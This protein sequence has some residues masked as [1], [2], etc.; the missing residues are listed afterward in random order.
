MFLNAF[1]DINPTRERHCGVFLGCIMLPASLAASLGRM[2]KRN[3][4]IRVPQRTLLFGLLGRKTHPPRENRRE[5][6]VI[7]ARLHPLGISIGFG[8]RQL[9]HAVHDH[10]GLEERREELVHRPVE[11][12]LEQSL[13]STSKS[14][15]DNGLPTCF[16]GWAINAMPF[17]GA[18]CRYSV[19]TLL[20]TNSSSPVTGLNLT[21]MLREALEVKKTGCRTVAT[22][23]F[24]THQPHVQG[25]KRWTYTP[26]SAS[27]R[28]RALTIGS[29]VATS[30]MAMFMRMT[31][32]PPRFFSPNPRSVSRRTTFRPP[33]IS[34]SP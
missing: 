14:T 1:Q 9:L 10:P 24:G 22:K 18:T 2:L 15:K 16:S 13:N 17:A 6:R 29:S 32:K 11:V 21:S 23:L 33:P 27:S 26:S 19:M 31:L 8:K 7:D 5:L 3:E 25:I 20:R 4:T 12:E 34:T 30:M 28:G